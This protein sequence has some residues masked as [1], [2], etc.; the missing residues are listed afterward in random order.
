MLRPI[1][2]IGGPPL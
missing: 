2:D 1:K